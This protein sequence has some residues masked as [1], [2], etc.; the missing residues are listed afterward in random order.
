MNTL[1]DKVAVALYFVLFGFSAACLSTQIAESRTAALGQITTPGRTVQFELTRHVQTYFDRVVECR[2]RPVKG[3]TQLHFQ[4]NF[5]D[6]YDLSGERVAAV[7]WD[8]GVISWD[9]YW[10]VGSIRSSGSGFVYYYWNGPD[11]LPGRYRIE[12]DYTGFS[13]GLG[14]YETE[15]VPW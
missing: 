1:A 3:G 7:N 8:D 15:E 5:F 10:Q 2:K 13:S 12:C 11:S 9:P 6:C 4:P 14:C